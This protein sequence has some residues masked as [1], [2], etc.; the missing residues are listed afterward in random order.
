MV[1][2][3]YLPWSPRSA[4]GKFGKIPDFS[5]NRRRS[6][7]AAPNGDPFTDS[8]EYPKNFRIGKAK[9]TKSTASIK[10]IF[11]SDVAAKWVIVELKL[12]GTAWKVCNIHYQDGGNLVD[13]LKY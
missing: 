1:H 10:V 4:I 3:S 12:E 11:P 9:V 6:K 5:G 8:Q 13:D 7:R 2:N